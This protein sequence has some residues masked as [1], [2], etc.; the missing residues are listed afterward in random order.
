[1]KYKATVRSTARLPWDSEEGHTTE[2]HTFSRGFQAN[3]LFKVMYLIEEFLNNSKC[4]DI[5][6]ELSTESEV[7]HYSR[8]SWMHGWTEGVPHEKSYC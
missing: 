5:M 2:T 6:M 1:M 3:S 4:W 7:K 8:A